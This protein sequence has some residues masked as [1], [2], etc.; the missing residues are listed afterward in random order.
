M[1]E[2]F[3]VFRIALSFSDSLLLLIL[4]LELLLLIVNHVS[5]GIQVDFRRWD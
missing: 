3:Q 4:C 1:V 5:E 2:P